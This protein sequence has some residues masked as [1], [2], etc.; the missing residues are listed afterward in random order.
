MLSTAF[1]DEQLDLG[2][3]RAGDLPAVEVASSVAH[4][5]RDDHAPTRSRLTTTSVGELEEI[6]VD[7]GPTC[8]WKAGADDDAIERQCQR[9][10]G[11][12]GSCQRV[13]DDR[14]E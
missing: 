14:L 10:P 9:R 6:L 2:R 7:V 13:P 1:V 8:R 4:A 11:L 3:Q 12:L 5:Q